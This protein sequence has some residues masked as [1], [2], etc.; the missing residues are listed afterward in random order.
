MI[1]DLLKSASNLTLILWILTTQDSIVSKEAIQSYISA[2][3]E[4]YLED[5]LESVVSYACIL[6]Y[7]HSQFG[8]DTRKP[9]DDLARSIKRMLDEEEVV[10]NCE[11]MALMMRLLGLVIQHP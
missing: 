11:E 7:M 2:I 8:I 10:F 6:Q 9:L 3:P 5:D 1:D 4:Q